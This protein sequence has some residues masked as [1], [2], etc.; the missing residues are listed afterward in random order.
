MRL[1]IWINFLFCLAR[2]L[3]ISQFLSS[4]K[5]PTVIIL[6]RFENYNG[7]VSG[8]TTQ[9][10]G[11]RVNDHQMSQNRWWMTV[12]GQNFVQIF[13]S[14][15]DNELIRYCLWYFSWLFEDYGKW[16][17]GRLVKCGGTLPWIGEK[18]KFYTFWFWKKK[19]K[20]GG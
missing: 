4:K 12:S 3:K 13:I 6:I 14:N 11:R 16:F 8:F 10:I 19:S 20:H 17:R 15:Y 5:F 1:K 9:F 2:R 7:K 18:S